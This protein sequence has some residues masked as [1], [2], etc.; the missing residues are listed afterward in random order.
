LVAF[1][2]VTYVTCTKL[3]M[4]PQGRLWVW[5]RSQRR[6]PRASQ[7]CLGILGPS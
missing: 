1:Q 2:L 7:G 3:L 4:P 6:W 5:L